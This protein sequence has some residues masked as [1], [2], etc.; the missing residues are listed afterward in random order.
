MANKITSSVKK[1][2]APTFASLPDGALFCL[3]NKVSDENVYIKAVISKSDVELV[4]RGVLLRTGSSYCFEDKREVVMY[5]PGE[6]VTITVG[7]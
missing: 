1:C 3:P 6:S 2:G 7:E 5:Q 4:R